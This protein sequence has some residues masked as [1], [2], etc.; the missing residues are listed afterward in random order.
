MGLRTMNFFFYSYL[1]TVNMLALSLHLIY[2]L[3]ILQTIGMFYPLS[4]FFCCTR[5]IPNHEV[6]Q[7][8]TIT[9]ILVT[10]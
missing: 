8:C 3:I 1:S 10:Q 9:P 4:F 7:R 2:Q 6:K 5:N